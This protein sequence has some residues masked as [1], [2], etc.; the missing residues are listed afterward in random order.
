MDKKDFSDLE[1]QIRDTV[2]SAFNAIDFASLKKDIGSKADDTLN[3]VKTK[4]KYKSEE[5][6][7]KI[8]DKSKEFSGKME[9]KMQN[10]MH[11]QYTNVA[12]VNKNKAPMY[13]SKRP[14]GRISGILY[15][16]FG[17]GGSGLFG[18][19]LIMYPILTSSFSESLAMKVVRG[20]L[21]AFF[22]ASIALFLRG[23]Y[24]R[25]RVKRFKQYVSSLDG[26]N[27]CSIEELATSIDRKN[28][29]VVKDL[30]KMAKLGMFKEVHIDD[31][32]THFML[33]N[34][35][36]DN[37]IK[38]QESLKQ[39]NEEELKRQE[40]LNEEINDPKKREL[41]DTIEMGK[42]Y[43]NQ[44]KS[45]N[46]A[47]PEEEIS[48]KLYRLEN[49][50]TQILDYIENNPKKLAEVNK[51]TNHYLPI[52]LKLVNSYKELNDQMVQGENIKS[53]KNEIEKS[54]D[55]IN[56]AFEK[57]LDDLFEEIALDIST[58][59]SVLET[60]FTQEGLTNNDFKK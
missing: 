32:Q 57:L 6:N 45:V 28:K 14:V 4:L 53:A 42:N 51:F 10:K 35:V 52:T 25:K 15:T 12:K 46:D 16:I 44:I 20:V 38:S 1:G 43:I 31:K 23:R 29:Y 54:I 2:K 37:Y 13:I 55:I 34:E 7:A 47:I 5:V 50:V 58:D 21:G 41:R 11:N 8:K 3:D 9:T 36:Y 39:R 19:L 59:I 17:F 24:L 60:L 30:R 48:K 33:S 56:I 18:V 40:K 27:Y 49:I 26:Q 22:V